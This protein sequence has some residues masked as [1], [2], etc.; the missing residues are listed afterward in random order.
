MAQRRQTT[1]DTAS[2]RRYQVRALE[3]GLAILRAF[4]GIAPC[5]TATELAD[6][7][8]LAKPTLFR[9]L[10]V[11]EE[12]RF[13]ARDPTEGGY[14]L[15]VSALDLGRVYL[16]SIRVPALAQ[17]LLDDLAAQTAETAALGVLQL[18]EVLVIAVAPGPQELAVNVTVGARYQPYCT[19]MGK[20]LLAS[21]PRDVRQ[22][23]LRRSGL[24]ARTRQPATTEETLLRELDQVAR[25]GLAVEEDEREVGVYS[26]A[27][28][29]R[30]HTGAVV[31]ALAM[32]APRYRAA[33]NGASGHAELLL[34]AAAELSRRIG[35][36]VDAAGTARDDFEDR[37]P[38]GS[39]TEESRTSGIPRKE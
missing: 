13:V 8:G 23:V 26:L 5:M 39:R 36:S 29:V 9:L 25:R 38:P 15:G 10:Q 4:D 16:S 28:P 22:R 18:D 34:A 20:V 33:S 19:A 14:R 6:K 37:F 12:G 1:I 32:T 35:G 2:D 7:V 27:A 21:L 3:R 31:A 11:L 30:D 24:A 17:P